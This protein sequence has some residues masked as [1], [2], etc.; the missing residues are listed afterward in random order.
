MWLVAPAEDVAAVGV[1]V[2]AEAAVVAIAVVADEA[3]VV[4][5]VTAVVAS[6]ALSPQ[7]VE[8]SL[9]SVDFFEA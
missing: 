6:E 9:Q 7:S 5:T 4:A 8:P 1:V 2:A 3:V